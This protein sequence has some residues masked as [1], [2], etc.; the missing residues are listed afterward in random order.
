LL[1]LGC[2]LALLLASIGCSSGPD[3]QATQEQDI[4]AAVQVYLREQ[5]TVN[6]DAMQMDVVN[7]ALDGQQAMATVRFTSPDG[8]TN[9]EMQYQL[10]QGDD[11]WKVTGSV[12]GG[13]HGQGQP[14][15]GLPPEHPP[16]P[17][18]PQEEEPS[19]DAA[20]TSS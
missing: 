1:A 2:V 18:Q 20:A 11:G 10:A 7:L 13:G 8:A 4:L 3:P 17:E 9:L 5:G 15:P 16:I 14:Q 12:S 19:E 6:P